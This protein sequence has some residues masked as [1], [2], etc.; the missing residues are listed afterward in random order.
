MS[1]VASHLVEWFSVHRDRQQ[2]G[3]VDVSVGDSGPDLKMFA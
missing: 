3:H 1:A 2:H